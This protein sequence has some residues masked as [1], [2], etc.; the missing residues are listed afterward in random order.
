M[1]TRSFAADATPWA[2]AYF[3]RKKP[4]TPRNGTDWHLID[5]T[6][7]TLNLIP[8]FWIASAFHGPV[9]QKPTFCFRNRSCAVLESTDERTRLSWFHLSISDE[10][11]RNFLFAT[12]SVSGFSEPPF[13]V[14]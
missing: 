14:A 3:V 6:C 8:A 1:V 9:T 4:W 13:V 10:F 2:V 7:T 11:A 12:P 5:G